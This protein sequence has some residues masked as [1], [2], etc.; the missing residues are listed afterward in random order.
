MNTNFL[1]PLRVIRGALPHFR[2]NQAGLI[3][4]VSSSAGIRGQAGLG[5]Y[6]SSKFALEG[7]SESLLRELS[8]FH[9]K[10]CVVDL[11]FFRTNFAAAAKL[12]ANASPGHGGN[13]RVSKPYIG[14]V[15][16]KNMERI[17]S[18]PQTAPN[19][20]NK[21]T[22]AIVDVALGEGH[23]QGL[24]EHLRLFLGVDCLTMCRAKEKEF[25]ANLDATEAMP[26]SVG[27]DKT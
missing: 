3:I 17:E 13:G 18:L 14:T 23:G 26:G 1:G 11:G 12:N 7:L 22:T 25:S 4:N 2:N 6:S 16:D 10:V 21:A 19:D 24:L 9:I 27:V 20:A 15:A 8:S 5:C